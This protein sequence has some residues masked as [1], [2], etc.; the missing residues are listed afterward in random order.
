M[1]LLIYLVLFSRICFFVTG[2]SRATVLWT[3]TP[4]NDVVTLTRYR[5]ITF[6]SCCCRFMRTHVNIFRKKSKIFIGPSVG[7]RVE[8][9]WVSDILSLLPCEMP[10]YWK[11][12]LRYHW[13]GSKNFK[14]L[15]IWQKRNKYINVLQRC[16]GEQR[17]PLLAEMKHTLV[18]CLR[19]VIA[20]VLPLTTGN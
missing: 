16:F 14:S 4:C 18:F 9:M 3:V 8:S 17:C 7:F 15:L 2:T 10:K 5:S 1:Q 13:K 12:S 11:S 20:F 6:I 19:Y